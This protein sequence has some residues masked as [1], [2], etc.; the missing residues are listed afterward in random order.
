MYV[1]VVVGFALVLW[2]VEQDKFVAGAHEYEIPPE[3]FKVAE[4]P[5]QIEFGDA[6]AVTTGC[7]LTTTGKHVCVP[8]KHAFEG[9]TQTFPDVDPKVIVTEFVPCPEVTV[10]P[11]GTVQL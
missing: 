6:D 8:V 7:A 3:E 11:A 1:V 10:A 9:V 4:A 2:Q 5:E